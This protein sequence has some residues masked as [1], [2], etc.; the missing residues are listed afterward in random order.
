MKL[1]AVDYHF[2]GRD[3]TERFLQA[4]QLGLDGLEVMVWNDELL[5]SDQRRL[6]QMKAAKAT[7][8]LEICSLLMAGYNT[9]L[10]IAWPDPEIAARACEGVRRAVDWAAAV[11]A[12]VVLVPF[13]VDTEIR[14]AEDFYR[15]GN[16]F[17]ELC[18]YAASQSVIL[19]FEST[20]AAEEVLNMIDFVGEE[21]FG[22]YFDIGNT[23]FQGRMQPLRS[24]SWDARSSKFT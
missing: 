1:G 11:G 20:L 5:A 12:R 8:G 3:D 18:P 23:A 10:G 7:S 24:A 22:C 9:E 17:R 21:G 19:G 13:F 6:D 2:K 15:V 14:S 4:R 16:A